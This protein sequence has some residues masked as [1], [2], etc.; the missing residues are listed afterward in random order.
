MR[1]VY[2]LVLSLLFMLLAGA[3]GQPY[4]RVDVLTAYADRQRVGWFPHKRKLTPATLAGGRFGNMWE[5]PELDGFDKYPA[6]LYASPLY[7]DGLKIQ[8]GEHKGKTFRVVI[9]AAST[10]YVY[11][12]NAARANGVA[13]CTILWKTHLD[14]PCILP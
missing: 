10:G 7:V 2:G 3:A 4:A 12:I 13:P 5:S 9:A 8:P 6:R 11:A 14:A 1:A